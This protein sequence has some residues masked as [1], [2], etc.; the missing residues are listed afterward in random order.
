M[1]AIWLV[2]LSSL[3]AASAHGGE[4][5]N[6]NSIEP[7]HLADREESPS[8]ELPSLPPQ[9]REL[10]STTQ[11]ELEALGYIDE[12]EAVVDPQRVGVVVYDREH[13][14]PGYNLYCDHNSGLAELVDMEGNVIQHW[15]EPNTRLWTACKLLPNGDLL[16]VG[17]NF[18][19][20]DPQPKRDADRRIMRLSWQGKIIWKRAIW[21]HHDVDL[22]P[23]GNIITLTYEYQSIPELHKRSSIRV[24]S[25]ALL[26]PDGEIIKQSSIVAAYQAS[27][28]K[29]KLVK[30]KPR[31][32][33]GRRQ[34]DIL[35]PNT[36]EWL[37]HRHLFERDPIYGP[38][39]VLVTSRVQ[40][41]VTIINWESNRVLWA[42]GRGEIIGPH[43]ATLLENGH[44]LLFDNGNKARGFSR[45]LEVDPLT[46]KIVWE[47]RAKEPKTFF[48]TSRGGCQRLANGN[49]LITNS[50]HG[51]AF[52]V[53]P[54]GNIVWEFLNPHLTANFHRPAMRRLE[55]YPA[56]FI[57]AILAENAPDN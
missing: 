23:D 38:G 37:D 21:A 13:A 44:V 36:V 55:R 35:H 49:T 16:G 11:A 2:A 33:W 9:Y 34:V 51:Q 24:D 26:T 1:R 56:A 45:I 5:R 48:T 41:L 7:T 10:G 22:T 8:E 54:E 14:Q 46:N 52:E 40:N 43:E 20:A 53:T 32:K 42:W 27:S 17:R 19:P 18:D 30:I 57:D 39:N 4:N 29:L 28:D 31:M 12:T 3:I 50:N 15:N 6:E 25:V 47:Y